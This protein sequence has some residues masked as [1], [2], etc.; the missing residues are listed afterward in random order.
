MNHI[1]ITPYLIAGFTIGFTAILFGEIIRR[2]IR[3]IKVAL[4]KN[5]AEYKIVRS[6]RR[7]V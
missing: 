2:A 4:G 3:D 1:D 6:Y 5:T 7:H